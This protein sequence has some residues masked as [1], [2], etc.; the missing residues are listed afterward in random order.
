MTFVFP[1]PGLT[2][3]NPLTVY[4]Q[5]DLPPSLFPFFGQ[6]AGQASGADTLAPAAASVPDS[7]S[8]LAFLGLALIGVAVAQKMMIS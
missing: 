1:D 3:G 6:N 8:T 7:G 5:S 4:A 2:T